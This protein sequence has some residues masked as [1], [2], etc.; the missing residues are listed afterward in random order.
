MLGDEGNFSRLKASR[1]HV[2]LGTQE[3]TATASEFST[4]PGLWHPS[5]FKAHCGFA[6]GFYDAL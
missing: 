4:R 6:Y 5:Y 1:I 3:Q 2:R